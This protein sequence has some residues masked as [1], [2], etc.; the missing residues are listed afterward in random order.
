MN[1]GACAP[2]RTSCA[3]MPKK[4][5]R[6]RKKRRKKEST[7]A[8][9]ARY[10]LASR[11]PRAPVFAC[12]GRAFTHLPCVRVTVWTGRFCVV[13]VVAPSVVVIAPSVVIVAPSV[14]VV[15]PSVVVVAPSVVVVAPSVVVVGLSVCVGESG[16]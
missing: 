8:T 5:E 10:V 12:R 15:T 7:C 14:V 3:F 1:P 11:G 4:M 9:C 2:A 13:V 16:G 6:I